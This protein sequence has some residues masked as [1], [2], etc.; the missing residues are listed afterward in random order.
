MRHEPYRI[1]Q[2]T[3]LQARDAHANV[4]FVGLMGAGK[5]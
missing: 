1:S 3:P 5:T 4:F 2:R